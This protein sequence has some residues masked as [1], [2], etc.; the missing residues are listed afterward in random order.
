LKK[1]LCIYNEAA[2][3]LTGEFG[4]PEDHPKGL[5]LAA[6]AADLGEQA[7][8]WGLAKLYLMGEGGVP[9]DIAKGMSMLRALSNQGYGLATAS[10]GDLHSDPKL[11]SEFFSLHFGGD[12][13]TSD[14]VKAAVPQDLEKAESYWLAATQQGYCRAFASL[15][16]AYDRGAGVP[17]NYSKAALYVANAVKC[18]L[19]TSFT[20]P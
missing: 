17:L 11:R 13:Q 6:Q 14:A 3:Y 12:D 19:Q 5:G 7:A 10:L 4:I 18:A 9:L 15:A 20:N 8:S 2:L 16:S 1:S